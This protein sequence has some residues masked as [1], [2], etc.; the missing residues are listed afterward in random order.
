MAEVNEQVAAFDQCVPL[1][2][3]RVL[4]AYK[5][6]ESMDL[7]RIILEAKPSGALFEGLLRG[8]TSH[9]QVVGEISRVNRYGN[10]SVCVDNPT[11]R[12]FCF[13]RSLT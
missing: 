1:T 6:E 7:L 2:L 9:F 4:D 10:Q 11:L 13:C 12:K 3:S 8:T 5:E